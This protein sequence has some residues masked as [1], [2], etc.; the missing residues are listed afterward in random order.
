MVGSEGLR[1]EPVPAEV[2]PPGHAEDAAHIAVGEDVVERLHVL[3]VLADLP[4]G[5]R[6]LA[7]GGGG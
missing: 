3:A 4:G 7:R 5:V 2:L 6:G 1:G